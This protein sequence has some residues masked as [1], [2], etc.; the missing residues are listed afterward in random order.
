MTKKIQRCGSGSVLDLDSIRSVDLDPYLKSGSGRTKKMTHKSRK[1]YE[2][3]CF[4]VR[5]VDPDPYLESG[6]G[7]TKQMTRKSRKKLQNFMF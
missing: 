1:K 5:S 3:S 4:E 7:R 6:S 2:I